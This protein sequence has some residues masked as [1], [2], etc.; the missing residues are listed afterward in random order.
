VIA[1]SPTQERELLIEAARLGP[2]QR[3]G[4]PP[5]ATRGLVDVIRRQG[6]QLSFFPLEGDSDRFDAVGSPAL[7]WA[8]PWAGFSSL[9]H[10]PPVPMWLDYAET[11]PDPHQPCQADAAAIVWGLHL[12][13]DP[14]ESGALIAFP[15]SGDGVDL[16]DRVAALAADRG[17]PDP[18]RAL[19]Q[20]K[21]LEGGLAGAQG[22]ARRQ[23]EAL[24]VAWDGLND[25]AGVPLLPL[26]LGAVQ[27]GV[28]VRI[29]DETDPATF[30]AYVQAENT[31]AQWLPHLRPLHF[32]VLRADRESA[33][34]YAAQLVRWI[35]VPVG[36]DFTAE[37]IG[38]AVLG[39]V[40]ASDYL[41]VRWRT[42]PARAASYAALMDT[43]YGANHDA[44]R[45]VFPTS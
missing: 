22:L 8:Q 40:K 38:H 17:Q 13:P 26:D 25:A 24:T 42:D 27:P 1:R 36:P 15:G 2:D 37:E 33:M 34:A 20:L 35:V 28:A 11:L 45:P 39:I 31:P 43:Q 16:Y 7:V 30:W 10:R 21:R 4:V 12:T 44:Y 32:L 9:I 3:V 19:A 23:R 41:G 29:P 14:A 5:N 18:R 6:R